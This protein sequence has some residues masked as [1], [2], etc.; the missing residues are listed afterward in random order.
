MARA[1]R[2]PAVDEQRGAGDE[3]RIVAGEKG[4]RGGDVFGGAGALDRL[5]L[6]GARGAPRIG[7]LLCL[8]RAP[9]RGGDAVGRAD[10]GPPP[11]D[12][13]VMPAQAGGGTLVEGGQNGHGGGIRYKRGR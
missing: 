10:G 3:R 7:P 1:D 6:A 4:D 9:Q 8:A 2:Q 12:E 13:A 5:R 11:R